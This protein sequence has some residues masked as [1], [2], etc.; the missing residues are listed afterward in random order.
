MKITK[1]T[2]ESGY[3]VEQVRQKVVSQK[4]IQQTHT[5]KKIKEEVKL[6]AKDDIKRY[7]EIVKSGPEVREERIKELKEAIEQGNYKIDTKKVAKKIL[8]DIILGAK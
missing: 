1:I 6:T 4:Q 7:K 8:E 5:E 3:N 2:L